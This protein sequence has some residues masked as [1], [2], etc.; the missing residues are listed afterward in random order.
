MS[1]MKRR[2]KRGMVKMKRGGVEAG[3]RFTS[4]G[5]LVMKLGKSDYLALAGFVCF[6]AGV[7]MRDLRGFVEIEGVV[8]AALELVGATVFLW[9]NR[10]QVK[11]ADKSLPKC[12]FLIIFISL[13]MT[14]GC[15]VVGLGKWV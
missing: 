15:L 12:F 10:G 2:E 9:M 3:K 5:A 8:G 14:L 7:L 11:I 1:V 4:L 6:G 13:L